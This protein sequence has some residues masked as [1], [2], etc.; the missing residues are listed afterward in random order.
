MNRRNERIQEIYAVREE[1]RQAAFAGR[2]AETNPYRN[3]N[4]FHWSEGYAEALREKRDAETERDAPPP[5][6][7][8]VMSRLQFLLTKLAEEG[9]EVAQIALKNQQFGL[10]ESRPDQTLTNVERCH[11]ELDDLNAIVE[12]LNDEF[13]FGY[14]PNRAGIDAKKQKVEKYYLYSRS[15]GL[16]E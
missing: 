3:M 6:K 7:A 1:G 12:I 14:A 4:R 5:A 16:V 11:R 2:H 15:L 10:Y 13:G 8:P 9:S